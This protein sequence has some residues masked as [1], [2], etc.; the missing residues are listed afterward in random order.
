MSYTPRSLF[1][2]LEDIDA[3]KLLLPHIQRPFVWQGHQTERLFD[4]LMR[5]YPI[6]TFLFWRT[7]E[8]IRARRFMQ[9]LDSDADLS[10]LYDLNRSGAGVEKTFVLDG[11]Q[12][13]QSL[14]SL[15]RGAMLN[16]SGTQE[17]AYFDVSGQSGHLA[18][19]DLL[20]PVKW[21]T[22]RLALPWF[23]IRDLVEKHQNGNALEIADTLNDQ[24]SGRLTESDEER[25]AR[26]R[27]VRSAISQLS[28]LLNHDKY[29]W[30]DELDGVAKQYPYRHILEIFVR[31]NSGGTKLTAGDL[32]FA[33]MK[34]GWEDVEA[35]IEQTLDLL[36]GGRLAI[37]SD[38]V[39]KALSLAHGEGSEITVDKFEGASGA[40]FLRRMEAEWD[41]AEQAFRELRDFMVHS[42]RL[43]ADRV[44]R[45]Y[46]ALIPL[47]VYLF[48]HPKP[49]ESSRV[50]MTAYFHKAQL[51]GWF[52]SQ[53]DATLNVLVGRLL[54]STASAFPLDEIKQ[55]FRSS[56]NARVEL[57]DAD[58]WDSRLRPLL[59]NIV[60]SRTW[61]E[62]PFNVSFKGNEPHVDHIYP[63]HMLRSR[64]GL[65][66]REINDIGN[67]RFVGAT[68]NIR[69]RAELPASY[70]A[71]LKASGV[72]IERH[73]LVSDFA[74]DPARLAFD[75]DTYHRFRNLRR[76]QILR[77]LRAVVDPDATITS[78]A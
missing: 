37:E 66:S 1:R 46:N 7:T 53:T 42:L 23:R 4:S 54:K 76:D 17:E 27:R 40:S 72:Q 36:N 77:L 26:E 56:R 32:M 5:D 15:F 8:P 39:L 21:S 6:Q 43:Q 71:R 14:H 57:A 47:F 50:R 64:L 44:V 61:G 24:L 69:K 68:D 49:D 52:S 38:F 16:A 34:E 67:L 59:L 20:Y 41:K 2:L 51:F 9:V 25:R 13:L 29:F 3:N 18:E 22:E 60:Y 35:R 62:S 30:I 33:A 70:F 48:H 55:Y 12:R 74:V 19:G 11:Q 65:W 78:E 63:Q 45:S 10:A 28:S 31:V 75:A 73:L 58:L